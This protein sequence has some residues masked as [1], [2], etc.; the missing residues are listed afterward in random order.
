MD[1]KID[2]LLY[3][4]FPFLPESQNFVEKNF[5]SIEDLVS[6]PRETII[7]GKTLRRIT[8]ALLNHE[9]KEI[10]KI[11]DPILI[12]EELISYGLARLIVSCIKNP[13][14]IKRLTRYESERAFF[15]LI[16]EG[17][18]ETGSAANFKDFYS[19]LS[20][21]IAH[22]IGIDI[23]GNRIQLVN[24]IDCTA[25]L[26]ETRWN[27]VNRE[28][29]KGYVIISNVSHSDEKDELIELIKQRIQYI[30]QKDLPKKV[31]SSLCQLFAE[32][33]NK[34]NILYQ[35]ISLQNFGEIE[36]G[37]FPPCIHALIESLTKGTN[38]T[39]AGRFALTTFLHN[40]GMNVNEIAEL[41]SRSPDFDI[42][43]TMYQVEH[44]TGRGG[45]GTE[46]NAPAC[47]GMVTTA[48]CVNRDKICE[49]VNHPLNYYKKKK[50]FLEKETGGKSKTMNPPFPPTQ[51]SH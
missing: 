47:P 19:P 27:L 28:L 6:G 37:A 17:Q 2:R 4:I 39:H 38:L 10:N 21:H 3:T 9:I 44:I 23:E 35:E 24:Y 42:S 49:Y 18:E 22:A 20:R 12:K 50:Y 11:S 5:N 8:N 45:S 46:Y 32:E 25:P 26:H 31:P 14:I 7:R 43:K 29:K 33:I 16:N 15:Y 48:L 1:F 36:E 40:I 41:Y 34:T 13:D 30:L 51:S